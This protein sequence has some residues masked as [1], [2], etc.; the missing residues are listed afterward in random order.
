ML[1][2]FIHIFIILI[3]YVINNHDN[4]NNIKYLKNNE[5]YR[6]RSLSNNLNFLVENNKLLLSD[7]QSPFLFIR[8]QSN[9]YYIETR[10]LR[11]RL[12]VDNYNNLIL[13]NRKENNKKDELI[14]NIIK[15]KIYSYN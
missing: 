5:V 10:R 9:I 8:K 15:V 4:K 13:Y 14:W 11:K 1:S 7:K 3:N 6:I 12:G 2:F